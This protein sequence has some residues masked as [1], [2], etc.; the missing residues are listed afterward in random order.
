MVQDRP[1]RIRVSRQEPGKPG[2]EPH[3]DLRG[4]SAGMRPHCPGS[5]ADDVVRPVFL[6][7]LCAQAVSGQKRRAVRSP[8]DPGR[9]ASTALKARVI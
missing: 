1:V 4:P 6:I 5:S 9:R 2:S 8:Y 7:T 3:E